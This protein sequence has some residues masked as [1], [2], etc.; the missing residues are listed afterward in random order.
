MQYTKKNYPTQAVKG[1]IK[2]G[3]SDTDIIKAI[4]GSDWSYI[5]YVQNVRKIIKTK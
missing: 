5:Q 1:A 2:L 4:F 3:M